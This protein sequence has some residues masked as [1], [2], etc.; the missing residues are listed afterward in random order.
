MSILNAVARWRRGDFQPRLKDEKHQDVLLDL[1]RSL[2][3]RGAHT[4][5]HFVWIAAHVGDAGNE[6]ADI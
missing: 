3:L 1:L 5:A 2:R 6:W 4:L